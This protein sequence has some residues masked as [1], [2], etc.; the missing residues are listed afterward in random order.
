VNQ[1]LQSL[2]DTICAEILDE[3]AATKPGLAFLLRAALEEPRLTAEDA[4]LLVGPREAK[5]ALGIVEII[6]G[7]HGR[8]A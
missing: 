7:R 8:T 6:V 4:A 2:D 3:L 5:W 1:P